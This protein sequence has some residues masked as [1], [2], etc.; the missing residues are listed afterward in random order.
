MDGVDYFNLAQVMMIMLDEE[1]R[2][3]DLNDRACEILG[4]SKEEAL[5]LDW[6][7]NFIPSQRRDEVRS[8]FERIM[9]GELDEIREYENEIITTSG[10][11]RYIRWRN[12]FIRD[13]EGRIRGTLS[14]GLDITEEIRMRQDLEKSVRFY[15][16]LVDLTWN[17]LRSGWNEEA[18]R[19]ILEKAVEALP[20]AHAGS[21]VVKA[22]EFYRYS[23]LVGYDFEKLKDIR[24]S[25]DRV[26]EFAMEPRVVRWKDR[27][28]TEE[29]HGD[30]IE[31]LKK[32]GRTDE[33]EATLIF[34]ITSNGDIEAYITLDNFESKDAFTETDIKMAQVFQAPLQILLW[35]DEMERRIRYLADHDSLT[36][37]LN[38]RAFVERLEKSLNLAKR[39][40][41]NL[42]VV[43]IDMNDFKEINDVHGHD[44]GDQV[45]MGFCEK[46]LEVLRVSDDVGRIGGDEFVILLNEAG[47]DGARSFIR[48]LKEIFEEPVTK[49]GDE[50]IGI[51]ISAG[52]ATFPDDG[53]DVERLIRIADER[54][55]EDK[56]RKLR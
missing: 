47:S 20:N 27:M 6:F 30:T 4:I 32:Y 55:Y 52:Y 13:L 25:P 9:R 53:E 10:E 19:R 48:R 18:L 42:S 29:V 49:C 17:I 11:K 51:S 46:L 40:G 22:G 41:R 37:V 5:G 39:Y 1:G 23:A 16:F 31:T 8:V 38:R 26:R 7:E 33:I 44:C 34:P 45:L 3:K 35:K 15:E 24:F 56:R 12:T 28:M 2:I 14:S 50:R 43:Y 54:M 21:V 36:G